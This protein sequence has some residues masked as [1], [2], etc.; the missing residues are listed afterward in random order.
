MSPTRLN[1]KWW[2]GR[3]MEQQTKDDI[4]KSHFVAE[5]FAIPLTHKV[6]NIGNFVHFL[7][8]INWKQLRG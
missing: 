1:G 3:A 6:G 4:A 8:E 7:M 2:N 5:I